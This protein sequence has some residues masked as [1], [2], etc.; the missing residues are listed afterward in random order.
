MVLVIIMAIVI[1]IVG[2]I[3]ALKVQDDV[4]NTSAVLTAATALAIMVLTYP[5]FRMDHDFLIALLK[6]IRYGMGSLAMGIDSDIVY[7]L[8]L[9]RPIRGIYTF[10]LYFLYL[11]GPFFASIFL[12][13]FSRRAIEALALLR[14]NKI[15]VFSRLNDRSI[16]MGKR[17]RENRDGAIIYC[18]METLHDESLQIAARSFHAAFSN[19]RIQDVHYFKNKK[20]CYYV[21]NDDQDET[22]ITTSS[23]CE[24]LLQ[25]KQFRNDKVTVRSFVSHDS[26]ELI[27]E[28]DK[29]LDGRID[30][31]YIDV[32]NALAISA[33]SSCE[34]EILARK[35]N[36][37]AILGTSPLAMAV[38]R[39]LLNVLTQ[40]DTTFSIHIYG[41]DASRTAYQL[42]TDC[43]ALLDQELKYYLDYRNYK[44]VTCNL[45]FHD[46]DIDE[47]VNDLSRFKDLSV[48]F[49]AYENDEDNYRLARKLK[50]D[51]AFRSSRLEHPLFVVSLK[52]AAVNKLVNK[53]DEKI[54][55]IGDKAQCYDLNN[56]L[57]PQLE[58]A[59]KRVHLAYA[60]HDDLLDAVE[61]QDVRKQTQQLLQE[62]GYYRYVNQNSSFAS[63]LAMQYRYDNI[64]KGK[65]EDDLSDAEYVDKYLSKKANLDTLAV[66]E[67]QR[68]NYYMALQGWRRPE[69]A[70]IRKIADDSEGQRVKDDELLL[71]PALVPYSSLKTTEN[72]VDKLLVNKT[73][74]YVEADKNILRKMTS[75]L[76]K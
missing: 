54:I 5:Y 48:L 59:A 10:L 21:I 26:L 42:K 73:S 40:P 35:N 75:I 3:L 53:D 65:K 64:L 25:N 47:T 62:E 68:W 41:K 16:E 74:N 49:I 28:L 22:L 6:N 43:P 17:L 67:H 63:A 55:Y 38:L 76:K 7:A 33:L 51:F 52:G 66:C 31:R 45:H 44:D 9:P 15:H 19:K 32:D 20:Y 34:S 70:Q 27:R 50:R 4:R 14:Y 56:L 71:H 12:V 8:D 72:S 57:T 11:M 18:D 23:L 29:S 24:K 2:I 46:L 36:E 30:L 60:G 37:I 58:E 69:T 13:S 61:S 1:I 39:N